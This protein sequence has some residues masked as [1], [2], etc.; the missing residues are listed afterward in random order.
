MNAADGMLP[1]ARLMDYYSVRTSDLLAELKMEV[2]RVVPLPEGWTVVSGASVESLV[3]GGRDVPAGEV[4]WAIEQTHD[5]PMLHLRVPIDAR[6]FGTT[7]Q[8]IIAQ[9]GLTARVRITR[10]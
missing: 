5:G 10:A 7:W 8:M 9:R 4:E 6:M 1:Q 2:H 3:S